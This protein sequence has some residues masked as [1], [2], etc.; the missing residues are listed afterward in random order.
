MKNISSTLLTILLALFSA[1]FFTGCETETILT[2]SARA[3]HFNSFSPKTEKA[4]LTPLMSRYKSEEYSFSDLALLENG[5]IWSVGFDSKPT[6][7]IRTDGSELSIRPF[8]PAPDSL[9]SIYFVDD[10]HGWAVGNGDIYR[11]ADGGEHWGKTDLRRNLNWAKIHF[12]NDKIGYLA[13][14]LD[15]KEEEAGEIWKTMDGGETW[16]KMYENDKWH[17]PYSILAISENTAL[18][19]LDS[20]NILRTDD[21]GKSWQ[22]GNSYYG[23]TTT[24]YKFLNALYK[25]KNSRIWALGGD[26]NF[27]YSLDSGRTWSRPEVFPKSMGSA[28]WD[29]IGFVDSK[30]GFA[31]GENGAFAAT[32]DGG[33]TWKS[34]E[35]GVTEHLRKIFLNKNTVLILGANNLYEVK[36]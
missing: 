22:V 3:T 32:Q 36:F 2:E 18:A 33:I 23:L 25:D 10:R 8:Y 34:I 15:V 16:V 24:S 11:T 14:K 6:R 20:E 19:L 30:T 29:T 28:D 26:G 12:F 9:S 31:A 7:N 35:S 27:F 13:V 21:G 5:G 1:F 17:T 4:V